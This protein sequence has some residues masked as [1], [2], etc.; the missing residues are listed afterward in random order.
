MSKRRR[1]VLADLGLTQRAL[2][3]AAEIH[4]ATVSRWLAGKTQLGVESFARLARHVVKHA[5]KHGRSV[6]IED[7][8]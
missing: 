3:K 1:A 4:E 8:L 2:A 6:T 5:Q 7:L